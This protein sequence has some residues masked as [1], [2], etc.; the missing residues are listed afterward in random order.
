MVRYA[1]AADAAGN[2]TVA[3]FHSQPWF[4]SIVA[5]G[6]I[7]LVSYTATGGA[8]FRQ[9]W[10][11]RAEILQLH[12]DAA[13]SLLVLGNFQDSLQLAPGHT[14][15]SQAAAL[16]PFLAKLD[17]TGQLQWAHSLPALLGGSLLECEALTTDPA[18]AIYLGGQQLGGGT[19]VWQL[20]ATG[21]A[22]AVRLL[23]QPQVARISSLSL[24]R[25][26]D[27]FVAGSCAQP[28]TSFNGQGPPVGDGYNV[29]LARYTAAGALR[30]ARFAADATCPSTYAV[31]D[32]HGG[33]YWTGGL[34]MDDMQFGP[35]RADGRHTGGDHFLV[36]LDTAG[37]W[38]WLRQTPG[39]P[40]HNG[41]YP[42]RSGGLGVD[43]TGNALLLGTLVGTLPG[44]ATARSSDPVLLSYDPA[45]TLRWTQSGG[46]P[47][48]DE[49]HS[50][51][52]APNGVAYLAGFTRNGTL[53]FG[54][55]Q[56]VPTTTTSLFVAQLQE[57]RPTA[58]R[59]SGAGQWQVAPNPAHGSTQV[60][61]GAGSPQPTSLTL[62]NI[63]GE[64]VRQV[65]VSAA[66]VQVPTTGLAPGLYL[67]RAAAGTTW[68]QARLLV[69]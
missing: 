63:L 5:L 41:L 33:V 28:L 18:T 35:W 67:L 2:V 65:P 11:G 31:A 10:T 51:A 61:F 52:L 62:H 37:T 14:L 16:T 24:G 25:N 36:R 9:Q 3:G 45:G 6:T 4:V 58:T 34:P 42:A 66:N 46:G 59:P 68:Y 29:Y 32:D 54:T 12:Y 50:L 8:R 17:A 40:L 23:Q 60:V 1:S 48:E 43:A 19:A 64:L 47:D 49:A 20:P 69:E 27:L 38:R 7:Q 26:G 57:A 53:R 22:P 44:S 13:G 21:Q 39:N 15:R 30:W 56:A 55:T